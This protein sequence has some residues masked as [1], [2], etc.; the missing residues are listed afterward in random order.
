ML[1]PV[2]SSLMG[3]VKLLKV[4]PVVLKFAKAPR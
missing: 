3:I 2:A 1:L 4:T